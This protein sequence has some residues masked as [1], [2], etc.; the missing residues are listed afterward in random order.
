MA[1]LR[2]KVERELA[3]RDITINSLQAEVEQHVN[4]RK[5]DGYRIESSEEVHMQ[6]F[7]SAAVCRGSSLSFFHYRCWRSARRRS[8]R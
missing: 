6:N 2:E 8:C 5:G 3:Q 4:Q 1:Q 7:N